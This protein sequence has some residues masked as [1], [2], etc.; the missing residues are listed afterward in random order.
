MDMA[1]LAVQ[2]GLSSTLVFRHVHWII[3]RYLFGIP[4]RFLF[5]AR[6]VRITLLLVTLRYRASTKLFPFYYQLYGL[7]K[8]W[9]ACTPLVRFVVWIGELLIKLQTGLPLSHALFRTGIA[10]PF[11]C[12]NVCV[13]KHLYNDAC[14]SI[15]PGNFIPFVKSGK[16]KL[17]NGEGTTFIL[18]WCLFYFS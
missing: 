13:D 15:A 11:C 5:Y 12:T 16:I 3:P 17:I 14:V 4:I 8:L 1:C 18:L 7:N 6:Y 9:A 2:H 10:S